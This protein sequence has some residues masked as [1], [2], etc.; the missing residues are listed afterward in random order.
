ME[1]NKKICKNCETEFIDE[2]GNRDFCC[3]LCENYFNHLKEVILKKECKL[4]G[5]KFETR[6]PSQLYCSLKCREIN[7]LNNLDEKYY[8]YLKWRFEIFKRDNFTCQYC[9]RNVKEDGVKLQAE[10][11]KPR[12]KGGSDEWEN[13]TTSCKECNLGKSDYCLDKNHLKKF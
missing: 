3:L 11:I 13:L 4:C 5:K 9:G 7:R 1:Q 10:H 8:P 12:S 6:K 2:D